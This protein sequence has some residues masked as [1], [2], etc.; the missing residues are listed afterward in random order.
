MTDTPKL[1]ANEGI[2]ERSRYLRGTIGEGLRRSETGSLVADDTQL[3]KFHG[4]YQQ[5][6]RDLRPERRRKKMEPAYSFMARVRIPGG[7]LTSAQ[8]LVMDRIASDFANGSIRLTTRQAIQFHGIIKTNLARSIATI[9]EALLDTLAACGDV[10]RNVMSAANPFESPAHAEAWDLA[11]RIAGHLAPRTR[12]YHEIWI[13]GEKVH[14]GAAE[15]TIE[16]DEEPI[17]GRT[18]LPRKFKIVV[19]VPPVS[20]VDLYAHDLG[21]AAVVEGGAVVGYNVTVGGGMGMTHGEPAT[22]PRLADVLGFCTPEQ[23]VDVAE[24]VVTVQRDFGDRADRKQA[25]LKYTIARRGLDWF[26]AEVEARLGYRLGEARPLALERTGDRFGWSKGADGLW[27]LCLYIANG[28]VADEM[29]TGLR[30]LAE[31]HEGGFVLTP[32][33]NLIVARVPARRKRQVETLL[34]EHGL[35][36]D[37][38]GLRRNAMA[39]VA[40]PSCGLALAESE[41]YLPDLVTELEAAI[42]RAGLAGDEIVVRMTGCPNGCAR[43]YLAE[44]GFVGRSPGVYDVFLGAAFDGSRPNRLYKAKVPQAEIAGLLGPI[45][46]AYGR[47]RRAGE[48]FGDFVIRTGIIPAPTG[49]PAEFH[50]AVAA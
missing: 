47:E 34:R 31:S 4:I 30:R 28:R 19:A 8:W 17:Y 41:R 2:K 35:L 6:D 26:R 11:G 25:R 7:V 27:H 23:A 16:D 42:E 14:D 39:C 20:D 18:Y 50:E 3:T 10:N 48:R 29:R 13:D 40:L 45:I 32:N 36:G 37:L 12:A 21:F 5:D 46:E 1:S 49:A 24:K 15:A 9:N 38:T 33:Q 22:Y 43:P 44:I